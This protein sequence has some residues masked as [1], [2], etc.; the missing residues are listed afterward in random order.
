MCRSFA[1]TLT[2]LFCTAPT[3]LT[4]L[5]HQAAQL[6]NDLAAQDDVGLDCGVTQVQVTVLQSDIFISVLG[7][8]DLEGQLVVDT[9]AQHLDLSGNNFDLTGG[10]LGVLALTLTDNAGDGDGGFLGDGLD[11]LHHLFVLDDHLR[12]AIVVTEHAEGKV[13]AH[14]TDIFQP[15]NDGDLLAG[16]CEAQ[17][18]AIMCSGLLHKKS[19]PYFF[20]FNPYIIAQ[21]P[22]KVNR[23]DTRN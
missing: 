22:T 7:L 13:I 5:S 16:V 14:F 11:D 3:S 21:C 20:Y 12:S 15:A 23:F 18:A 17:L 2:M 8:V 6:G 9:L 1:P 19:L 10:D 4:L